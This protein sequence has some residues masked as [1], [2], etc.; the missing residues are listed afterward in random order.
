VSAD[1][2]R[3]LSPVDRPD[4]ALVGPEG[5]GSA[6]AIVWPGVG[7]QARTMHLVSL[8]AGAVSRELGHGGEAVYYVVA[9]TGVVRDADAGTTTDLIEGSM[10]HVEPGTRY[11]F[12]AGTDGL[13]LVGGPGP[14]DPDLYREG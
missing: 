3:V 6:R 11:A 12:A 2:V 13:E 7:A 1:T 10:V 9:G 8:P 5:E 4:V 14:A